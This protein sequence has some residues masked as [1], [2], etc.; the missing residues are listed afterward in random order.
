MPS[1]SR[2]LF[3]MGSTPSDKL[4]LIA[5]GFVGRDLSAAF[6]GIDVG[7]ADCFDPSA[8]DFIRGEIARQHGSVEGFT[9]FLRLRFLLQPLRY[10]L[11]VGDLLR[12]STDSFD[13]AP[14]RAWIDGTTD[15]S[16][17]EG[18]VTT[19]GGATGVEGPAEEEGGGSHSRLACVCGASGEGK[20]TVSAALIAEAG[21][22]PGCG[23]GSP[24][25]HAH[26]L[27]KH[28]DARRRDPVLIAK[29]LAHQF[30]GRWPSVAARAPPKIP[31]DKTPPLPL[32][33]F[34]CGHNPLS[35]VNSRAT[36]TH[37]LLPS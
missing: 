25:V 9:R 13:F 2:C 35:F 4:S 15:D 14:L 23:S 22:P 12:R 33:T 32:F 21:G 30:A 5:H 37:L 10:D 11:D 6:S 8:R 29:S 3:E 34:V 24:W 20:S 27:C 17:T 36:T 28:S 1:D 26:H 18:G 19:E 16:A 7:S 31:T